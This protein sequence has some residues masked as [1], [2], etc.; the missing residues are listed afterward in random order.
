MEHGS[1]RTNRRVF[2]GGFG[3]R[4]G[5]VLKLECDDAYRLRE[6]ADSVKIAVRCNYFNI[7]DLAGGSISIR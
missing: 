4:C 7:G 3:G 1:G 5:D 2:G 6:P